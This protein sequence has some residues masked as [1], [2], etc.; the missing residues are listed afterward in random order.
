M[1]KS[2][3]Y[4]FFLFSRCVHTKSVRGVRHYLTAKTSQIIFDGAGKVSHCKVKDYR[5]QQ[6]NPFGTFEEAMRIE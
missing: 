4:Q 3:R 2:Q 6:Q 5:I 1:K